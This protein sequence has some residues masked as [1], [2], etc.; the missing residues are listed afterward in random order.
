MRVSELHRELVGGG[1][2]NRGFQQ[3]ENHEYANEL[4]LQIN[5]QQVEQNNEALSIVV[6]SDEHDCE[7]HENEPAQG[8]DNQQS[9]TGINEDVDSPQASSRPQGVVFA[10]S[11]SATPHNTNQGDGTSN[12]DNQMCTLSA[13]PERG[14]QPVEHDENGNGLTMYVNPVQCT[15]DFQ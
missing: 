9:V 2:E 15:D 10:P 5:S 8:T 6:D 3:R 12:H 7:M 1:V 4:F 13:G 14:N 11:R